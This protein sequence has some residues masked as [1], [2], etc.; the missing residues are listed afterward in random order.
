MLCSVR[1]YWNSPDGI[2]VTL[3]V[4]YSTHGARALVQRL[5]GNPNTLRAVA[6]ARNGRILHDMGPMA[7][8]GTHETKTALRRIHE[9]GTRRASAG[10]HNRTLH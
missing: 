1:H 4:A 2:G 5:S 3:Y 9:N 7:F 6:Q 8:R 10:V